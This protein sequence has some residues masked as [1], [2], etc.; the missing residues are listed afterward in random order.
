MT[1]A[2]CVEYKINIITAFQYGSL[3]AVFNPDLITDNSLKPETR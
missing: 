2:M 1:E 3:N